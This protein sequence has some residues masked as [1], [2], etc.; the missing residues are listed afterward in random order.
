MRDIEVVRSKH[1]QC[2]MKAQPVVC[3]LSKYIYFAYICI[4]ID[5]WGKLQEK[6]KITG[7]TK[8]LSLGRWLSSI[9]ISNIFLWE[10]IPSCRAC[11]LAPDSGRLWR[12]PRVFYIIQKNSWFWTFLDYFLTLFMLLIFISFCIWSFKIWSVYALKCRDEA[13]KC[14]GTL[15][16]FVFFFEINLVFVR[17]KLCKFLLSYEYILHFKMIHVQ[18]TYNSYARQDLPVWVNLELGKFMNKF[19]LLIKRIK[20]SWKREFS[21]ESSIRWQYSSICKPF[22]DFLVVF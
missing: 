16:L 10:S 7:E 13:I 18:Y 14:I 20:L 21:F 19:S 17:K 22:N 6:E 11:Q 12:E 9:C 8:W 15:T 3:L 4:Y 1:Y 5:N 2:P